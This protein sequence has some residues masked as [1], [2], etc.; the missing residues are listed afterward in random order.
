M[1]I[2]TIGISF[3]FGAF[4]GIAVMAAVIMGRGK[5]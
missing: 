5:K 3:M 2:F 1:M 4:F